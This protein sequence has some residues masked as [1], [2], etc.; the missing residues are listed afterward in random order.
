MNKTQVPKQVL[1]T[2]WMQCKF[3]ESLIET[4]EVVRKS[5]FCPYKYYAKKWVVLLQ[6]DCI[7][8]RIVPEST[9]NKKW[10]LHRPQTPQTINASGVQHPNLLLLKSVIVIGRKKNMSLAEEQ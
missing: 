4:M 6:C 9:T 3:E 1:W 7:V 5:A 8:I 2:L 10:T